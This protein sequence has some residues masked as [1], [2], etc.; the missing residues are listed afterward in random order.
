MRLLVT[1]ECRYVERDGRVFAEG[2]FDYR[3]LSRYLRIFDEV[4]VVAR[5]GG[6]SGY[7]HR[8]ASGPGVSFCSLKG[9]RSPLAQA[10]SL[11][12]WI[13]RIRE[14]ASRAD[15]IL[16]RVPGIVSVV[17]YLVAR[18]TGRPFGVEV[19]GD[20]EASLGPHAFRHWVGPLARWG[21]P[22]LLRR[23]CRDAVVAAYVTE[24]ALQ[25]HY[26]PGGWSTDYSSVELLASDLIP[27]RDIG[28]WGGSGGRDVDG[29]LR[30]RILFVG[31][32]HQLYKAP[33]VLLR[34]VALLK[35]RGL[36]F[37]LHVIGDGSRRA[38]LE[39]LSHR[40]GTE[41][42][43]HFEGRLPRELVM[44]A[45]ESADLFVLPSRQEGLPR[46]VIEAMAKG[47]PC[48]GSTVGGFGELLDERLLV[49]PDDPESLADAI[50]TLLRDPQEMERQGRRNRHH[51][52][53]TSPS[54]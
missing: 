28:V 26:P 36:C 31:N 22:P 30:F 54:D 43:V 46:A 14:A 27:E 21:M 19:V 44:D 6:T 52:E 41:D 49:P 32:L 24:R 53:N 7:S 5:F 42:V 17:S 25:E 20:P 37:E 18:F 38:S 39:E 16:L 29:T 4:E 23:Q 33:D 3:F 40:L 13:A 51:V 47:L 45:L 48:I 34:A 10:V 1:T 15:A 8:C 35:G 12:S 9:R 2:A 11:P 50:L